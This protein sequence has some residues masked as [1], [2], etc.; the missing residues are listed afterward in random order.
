MTFLKV[1]SG[2]I[3]GAMSV[4]KKNRDGSVKTTAK[5]ALCYVEV[6][7]GLTVDFERHCSISAP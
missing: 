7:G 3:D 5:N 4:S 6:T 1:Y 2:V